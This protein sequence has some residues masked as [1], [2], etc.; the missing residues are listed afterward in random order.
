[1]NWASWL[2]WGFAGTVFLTTLMVTGQ[3]FG[4]TRMNIPYLLGTMFSA[5]R[6]RAKA[7]VAAREHDFD[8]ISH[9]DYRV[10]AFGGVGYLK[11]EL[12]FTVA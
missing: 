12:D 9:A 7:L 8:L 3:G 10:E 5:N 11:I 2:V 1:M 6:D 4:I